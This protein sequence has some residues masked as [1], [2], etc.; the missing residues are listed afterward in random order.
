[1]VVYYFIA[2]M[3]S[4]LAYWAVDVS[5]VPRWLKTALLALI[6]AVFAFFAGARATSV[7]TDVMVYGLDAFLVAK[8]SSFL[9]FFNY[10]VFSTWAPL[11]KVVMWLSANFMKSLFWYFAIIQICTVVPVIW[12]SYKLTNRMFPLA[13]LMYA[14]IF[15]PMS[16][17]L[18][19]Q[20]MGMGFLLVAYVFLSKH[21]YTP[22]I[23]YTVVA[24][25]LHNACL[26]GFLVLP[27]FLLA[28]V[29]HISLPI[30]LIIVSIVG[31]ALLAF[32]STIL[33]WLTS[34]TGLYSDYT[35]GSAVTSGGGRRT[36]AEILVLYLLIAFM[37]MVFQKDQ[38]MDPWLHS[39]IAQ[40]SIIV[41]LGALTW[42]LG[43]VSL[44]LYRIGLMLVFY[45]I[46]LIPAIA[47]AISRR[48]ERL[49]FVTTVAFLLF[50][51]STDYYVVQLSNEVVPYS[52]K[53]NLFD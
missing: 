19:R 47:E 15:Y 28:N 32:S 53:N 45:C 29:E 23:I 24:A 9:G 22:F 46:L 36:A 25:L 51:F 17:N 31:I 12:A 20:F 52:F 33:P 49:F 44:W 30:K 6:V 39:R 14:L 21:R 35:T 8:G 5:R 38:Q 48:Q 37:A 41:L 27:L 11:C 3:T 34:T 13:V 42:L 18:M 10:S 1:M 16:F 50:V 26:V 43:L 4:L 7:G 40:L 2:L